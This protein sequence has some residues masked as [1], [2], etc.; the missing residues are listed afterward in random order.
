MHTWFRRDASLGDAFLCACYM[1]M[2]RQVYSIAC[3][4]PPSRTAWLAAHEHQTYTRVQYM[5]VKLLKLFGVAAN[6]VQLHR[7]WCSDSSMWR[8]IYTHTHQV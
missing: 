3:L 2:S 5:N 7:T 8:D 4:V 1:H 6:V